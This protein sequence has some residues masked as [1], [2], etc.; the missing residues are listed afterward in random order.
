MGG[1]TEIIQLP[2]FP[3]SQIHIGF[4][5]FL[6]VEKILP[7]P[8]ESRVEVICFFAELGVELRVLHVLACDTK[9]NLSWK[10]KHL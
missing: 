5:L 10:Q 4:S 6:V 2:C 9:Y 1:R 8:K 7:F 3:F